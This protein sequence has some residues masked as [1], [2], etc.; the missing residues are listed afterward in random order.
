MNDSWLVFV[1]LA[2]IAGSFFGWPLLRHVLFRQHIESTNH[3]LDKRLKTNIQLFREHMIE[4]DAA[5]AEGRM[6]GEQHAQL[7]LEQERH[8]LTDEAQLTLRKKNIH[9]GVSGWVIT[10]AGLLLIAGSFGL[11]QHWG[12]APDV[13]IQA[14][15]LQKNQLDYQDLLQN[16]EPDKARSYELMSVLEERLLSKPESTQHW[17]MLARTS[18]EIGN[19]AGAVAA[20]QKLLTL[21]PSASIVMAE[22]AQAM[23]L[24]DN[25]RLSPGIAQLAQSSL[26]ID[27]KNTTALGLAGIAAFEDKEFVAAA[28]YWERAVAVLGVNAAGSQALQNGIARARSEAA[29]AGTELTK[30]QVVGRSISLVVRLDPAIQLAGDL[31]VFVY[32]RAWQGARMP[33][34]IQR[35]TVAQL[36][37]TVTLD[38]S[39]AMS[40]AASLAQASSV[41][42]VA[43][44]A[45]DGSATAKVGDWQGSL[46]PLDLASLPTGIALTI[47]QKL[48]E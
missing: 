33:L 40:P 39:M 11:Y 46:G 38:E 45:M 28:D 24:R 29:K 34:A 35:L 26:T 18:M 12:S 43:R 23:F 5:L 47:D 27:P 22:L 30:P 32:A 42:L 36:P 41:E 7:K 25:N 16:R 48:T 19:F 1:V 3:S 13:A 37:A 9:F 31:P 20:Y 17:F 6:S 2:A 21:D 15:Q 8:L 10:M 14:L 44:V 4:L